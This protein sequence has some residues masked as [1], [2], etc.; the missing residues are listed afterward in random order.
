MKHYIDLG[1]QERPVL[2]GFAALYQYEQRTG[3][4]AL[5]DF[6]SMQEAGSISLLVDLLFAGLCAG[7]RSEGGKVDFAPED[8]AEWI[9]TDF[10][11]FEKVTTYFAASFPTPDSDEEKKKKPL[12][13][14]AMA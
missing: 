7:V 2:F 6:A 1:G 3:R 11:I 12:K 8:V 9:G 5:N 10:S 4:N 13:A 14:K